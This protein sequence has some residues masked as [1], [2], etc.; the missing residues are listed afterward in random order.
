MIWLLA[1][2]IA[3]GASLL[4]GA[5]S[6]SGGG[7]MSTAAQLLALPKIKAFEG[8]SATPYSDYMQQ[9]IGYG[10]KYTAGVTPNPISREQAEALL[11]SLLA[12]KYQPGCVHA[13][14]EK[15][16][17]WDSYNV[18]QQAA[19][20]SFSYNLGPDI[21]RTAT[22]PQKYKAGNIS[23]AKASWLAHNKA[24]GQV[25]PAL[26]ARRQEEWNLFERGY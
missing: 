11:V 9:S 21:C 24:S 6:A 17:S 3:V 19:I 14:G 26:V 7:S 4:R 18:G 16:I 23:G 5:L 22:W 8:F 15:G 25:L 13:L 20:L 1:A 2:I 12:S 10:S